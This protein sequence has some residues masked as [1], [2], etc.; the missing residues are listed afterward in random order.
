MVTKKVDFSAACVGWWLSFNFADNYDDDDDDEDDECDDNDDNV[1]DFGDCVNQSRGW[2]QIKSTLCA[3]CCATWFNC[4]LKSYHDDVDDVH[5]CK[6][7]DN[8][9]LKLMKL[10]MAMMMKFLKNWFHIF[11]EAS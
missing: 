8:D 2:W 5:C 4:A 10:V 7:V 6:G 9:D 11:D 1:D 3:N